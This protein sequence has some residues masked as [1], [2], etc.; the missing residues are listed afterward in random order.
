MHRTRRGYNARAPVARPTTTV[1]CQIQSSFRAAR[2]GGAEPQE[3]HGP[4]SQ[5]MQ[6]LGR[7]MAVGWA[8]HVSRGNLILKFS[9]AK[10][11]YPDIPGGSGGCHSHAARAQRTASRTARR[12]S[13]TGAWSRNVSLGA[14]VL[15][16]RS[17]RAPVCREAV[18]VCADTTWTP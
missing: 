9:C 16:T 5:C 2:T 15:S 3:R 12:A 1:Q 14:S 11:H 18:P 10:G 13:S 17:R 8:R 7:S 6:I 4:R